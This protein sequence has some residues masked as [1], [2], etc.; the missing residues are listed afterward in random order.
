MSSG[1]GNDS[2]GACFATDS[3]SEEA[4]V[5]C[6]FSLGE[7]AFLVPVAW[8]GMAR[9]GGGRTVKGVPGGVAGA[10]ALAAVWA[11]IAD[12]TRSKSAC[13]VF[14]ASSTRSLSKSM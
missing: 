10:A 13:A 8:V 6:D 4:L 1:I 5:D 11:R 12:V 9:K 7:D 3:E 14:D 2:E